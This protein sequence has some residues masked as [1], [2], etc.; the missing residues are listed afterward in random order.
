MPPRSAG[1]VDDGK[2]AI[3]PLGNKGMQPFQPAREIRWTDASR[4]FAQQGDVRI[5]ITSVSLKAPGSGDQKEKKPNQEKY[6]FITLR[7]N[8]VGV[9]RR[10]EYASWGE[11]G[12][13][14][15]RLSDSGGKTYRLRT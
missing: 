12:E 4:E 10:V 11:P 6:L 9:A 1:I 7:L 8:N 14:T 13:N 3:V 2:Q 5:R 15:A